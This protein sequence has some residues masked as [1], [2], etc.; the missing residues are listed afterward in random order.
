[1]ILVDRILLD[2]LCCVMIADGTATVSEK[3]YLLVLMEQRG[4]VL[5][6]QELSGH[7]QLFVDR[8]KKHGFKQV[9]EQVCSKC[10]EQDSSDVSGI[11][12]QCF[13]LAFKDGSIHKREKQTIKLLERHLRRVPGLYKAARQEQEVRAL[14]CSL[15]NRR[16]I[17]EAVSFLLGGIIVAALSYAVFS[18]ESRGVAVGIGIGVI[19][20]LGP[21]YIVFWSQRALF[22]RIRIRMPAQDVVD[23]MG[24]PDRTFGNFPNHAHEWGS[25]KPKYKD[26]HRLIV[27]FKD[28]LVCQK[29][30]VTGTENRPHEYY[31]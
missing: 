6:D 13:N 23:L 19:T 11:I 9:L 31:S 7:I 3:R 17:K 21:I 2:M 10:C 15:G 28:G 14:N 5:T 25:K 26:D 18:A 20:I 12:F 22:S 1:M 24:K 8:V 29:Q 27:T 30:K 4:T 16:P